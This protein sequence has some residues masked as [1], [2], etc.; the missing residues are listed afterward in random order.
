MG[1]GIRSLW[2]E[3]GEGGVR[4]KS[5]FSGLCIWNGKLGKEHE[6]SIE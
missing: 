1:L 6:F 4:A 3:K 5:S 2:G